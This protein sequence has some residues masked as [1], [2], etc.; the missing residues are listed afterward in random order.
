[1]LNAKHVLG[2]VGVY[3]SKN[4]N[5]SHIMC[6]EK[7][8]IN[9]SVPR[10]IRWTSLKIQKLCLIRFWLPLCSK[11]EGEGKEIPEGVCAIL[12]CVCK[13]HPESRTS[14]CSLRHKVVGWPATMNFLNTRGV[15][16]TS[17]TCSQE[18]K[19]MAVTFANLIN[20]HM[21]LCNGVLAVIN[22]QH[23]LILVVF[24]N[25]WLT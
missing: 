16:K 17:K 13:S 25:F 1:M 15:T 6:K 14:V 22:I 20:N 7:G 24:N 19:F 2:S 3:V 12:L 9:W 23:P 11:T 8:G 4:W 18:Q 21:A 5:L 10:T